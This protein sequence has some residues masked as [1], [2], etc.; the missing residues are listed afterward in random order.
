ML[1]VWQICWVNI[2]YH[3]KKSVYAGK[4][5]ILNTSLQCLL[6]LNQIFN[7]KI[8]LEHKYM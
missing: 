1:K 8:D 7:F 5:N 3:E 6:F 4:L 2:Y